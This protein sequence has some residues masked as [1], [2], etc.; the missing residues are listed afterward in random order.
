M[1]DRIKSLTH[2]ESLFENL[3]IFHTDKSNFKISSQKFI[4][5][6]DFFLPLSCQGVLSEF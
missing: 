3:I 1:G 2:F 4:K 5:Y 6:V